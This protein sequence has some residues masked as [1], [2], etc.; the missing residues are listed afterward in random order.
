MVFHSIGIQQRNVSCPYTFHPAYVLVDVAGSLW[1]IS[2]SLIVEI[3]IS[4]YFL[5]YNFTGTLTNKTTILKN[6]CWNLLIEI[7][8]RPF[9]LATPLHFS[10]TLFL[11]TIF[12]FLLATKLCKGSCFPS[13]LLMA[14]VPL[15]PMIFNLYKAEIKE[16]SAVLLLVHPLKDSHIEEV[17]YAN[18]GSMYCKPKLQH[19]PN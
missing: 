4:N 8:D 13:Y 11:S 3:T 10:W 1:Q 7:I 2:M 9:T 14:Q 19:S 17:N 18:L 16:S 5:K 6:C 15:S 12:I